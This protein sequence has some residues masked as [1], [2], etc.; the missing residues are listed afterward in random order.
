MPLNP[1]QPVPRPQ[2]AQVHQ[3]QQVPQRLNLPQPVLQPQ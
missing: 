3:L 2:Q 1:H